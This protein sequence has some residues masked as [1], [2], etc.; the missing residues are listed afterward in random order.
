MLIFTFVR[1]TAQKILPRS[2]ASAEKNKMFLLSEAIPWA[3]RQPA[4][5]FSKRKS[6]PLKFQRRKVL[7]WASFVDWLDLY[8]YVIIYM[9]YWHVY[10]Y[11]WYF[12]VVNFDK[13]LVTS[14]LQWGLRCEVVWSLLGSIVVTCPVLHLGKTTLLWFLSLDCSTYVCYFMLSWSC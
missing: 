11:Y 9:T 10:Y 2:M 13:F 6:H 4:V 3:K 12:L 14:S 7:L 1:A 8:S 5:E